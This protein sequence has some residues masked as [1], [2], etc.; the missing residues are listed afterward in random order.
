MVP[1]AGAWQLPTTAF[2]VGE[3][4]G[5]SESLT[6]LALGWHVRVTL[7]DP[8]LDPTLQDK[9]LIVD[10]MTASPQMDGL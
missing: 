6:K 5:D 9:R 7:T 1:A 3:V 8:T 2:L 10:W 4:Y